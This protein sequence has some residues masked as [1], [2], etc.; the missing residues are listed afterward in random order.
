[1]A[2]LAKRGAVPAD[3]TGGRSFVSYILHLLPPG[4]GFVE[5]GA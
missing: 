4:T 1:M 2:D 5:G 3:G